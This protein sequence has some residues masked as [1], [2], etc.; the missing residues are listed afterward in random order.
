MCKWNLFCFCTDAETASFILTT[1]KGQNA[2]TWQEDYLT[3][4]KARKQESSGAVSPE[5]KGD[6][7][8]EQLSTRIL[9]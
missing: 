1:I 7:I 5:G 6:K 9:C 4:I 8:C 3:A 2:A